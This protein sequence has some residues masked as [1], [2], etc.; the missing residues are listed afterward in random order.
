MGRLFGT[1]GVRGVAN[2]ELTVEMIARL[3]ATIGAF[4]GREIA[5]GRDGRTTSPMFRDAAISGLLSVGCNVHDTGMLPTPA[6]QHAVKH[7]GLGG[8]IMITASHNPPEFNGIKVIAS[9]GVEIPREHEAEIEETY[10]GE[11]PE[12]SPWDKIGSIGTLQAL[13]AYNEAVRS[14]VD[15]VA[16]RKAGLKI[17]IDPGNGVAALTAPEIARDLGCSVY[18]VNVNVNGRFPGRDSEPRPDNLD[19]LKRLV[20]ASGADLGIAFDGDGD[21]SMFVDE[22]GEVQWG[23]RS[24][25][26]LAKDFMTKNPGERVVSAVNSS[27]VLDD[28]VTA[29]GGS[30]VRTKVGSVVISR[31]MVDQGIMF[32]GEENGGIM[33]G[34]HLQ[35]RDGSM[36]MALMLEI[37]AKAKKPLSELF[38]E[39]P[40]YHQLKDRVP[41]PEELKERALEALRG[42]VEAPEV[43]TI[44]GVKLGYDDGSWVLF[45]PSGTEP[46]FRIYAEAGSPERVAELV[47]E[48]KA[49]IASVIESLG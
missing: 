20:R 13:E 33:Y 31:V 45:R 17:A 28:V 7:N 15:V 48:H 38:D 39:L 49:L 5:V 35:V 18:T 8:G 3:A 46:V 1:N 36:A 14:H 37:M 16:I 32:G 9:D 25:A 12:P 41:C 43:G 47:D 19:G 4:L 22:K 42:A 27:K 6:L 34:P 21:R 30:V 24:V 40:R 2:K 11:G 10:F 26:L 23:D 44:D 29:A